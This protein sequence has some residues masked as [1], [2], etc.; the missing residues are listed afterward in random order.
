MPAGVVEIVDVL[1]FDEIAIPM[2]VEDG[3]GGGR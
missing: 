1:D 2:R 3:A